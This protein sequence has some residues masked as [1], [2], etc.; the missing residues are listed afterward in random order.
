MTLNHEFT[1][2]RGFGDKIKTYTSRTKLKNLPWSVD[3]IAHI[4]EYYDHYNE[5]V[6]T[7]KTARDLDSEVS[8]LR[9]ARQYVPTDHPLQAAISGAVDS[10]SE[11]IANPTASVVD[12]YKQQLEQVKADYIEFYMQRYRSFCINDLENQERT[13]LLNSPQFAVCRKL[14]EFALLNTDEWTHLREDVYK[15]KPANPN[16][17]SMLQ[18]SPYIDFNPTTQTHAPRSVHQLWQDLDEMNNRWLETLRDFCKADEQQETMRL[19]P[20][21]DQNFI[22]RN[23]TGLET[24]ADEHAAECLLELLDKL[25]EGYE[26][27]EISVDTMRRF[28]DRPLTM[29]QAQVAF[30]RYIIHMTR[31]KKEKK[32]RIILK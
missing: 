14:S 25:G 31:G 2:L 3:D 27:V 11:V 32:V 26:A 29:E 28:F 7:I 12:A 4:C 19:M 6:K 21:G 30:D 20:D 22:N 10:F 9:Q 17:E 18:S 24:I 1:S 8:Y 23:I 5:T 15:L 13:R 16:A